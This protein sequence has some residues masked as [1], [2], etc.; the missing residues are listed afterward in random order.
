MLPLVPRL[1]AL[2]V[3][4][5]IDWQPAPNLYL[6]PKALLEAGIPMELSSDYPSRDPSPLWRIA[7]CA[8]HGLPLEAVI[9]SVTLRPAETEFAEKE[10]GSITVGKEADLIVMDRDLFRVAPEEIPDAKVLLTLFAGKE[11]YRDPSFQNGGRADA[12]HA[13]SQR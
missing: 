2:G 11:L 9:D 10:T 3:R 12:G 4:A 8:K 5:D 1:K 6:V 7:E 13:E